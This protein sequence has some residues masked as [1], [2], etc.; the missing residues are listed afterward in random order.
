MST[1]F[2]KEHFLAAVAAGIFAIAMSWISIAVL[3]DASAAER[4][5]N[6]SVSGYRI[7][8]GTAPVMLIVAG[9]LGAYSMLCFYGFWRHRRA[10]QVRDGL[11]VIQ[12]S[13]DLMI[14]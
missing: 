4:F 13:R 12:K 7:T 11:K 2:F 3:L 5:R 8:P 1:A 10:R 9:L 14:W 6:F